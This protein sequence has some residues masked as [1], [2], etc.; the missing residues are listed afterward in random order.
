MIDGPYYARDDFNEG[1]DGMDASSIAGR[2]GTIASELDESTF[3]APGQTQD[4]DY[5]G[6]EPHSVGHSGN[7]QA[8]TSL[9]TLHRID[10]P[11]MMD[12]QASSQLRFP[13]PLDKSFQSEATVSSSSSDIVDYDKRLVGQGYEPSFPPSDALTKPRVRQSTTPHKPLNGQAANPYSKEVRDSLQSDKNEDAAPLP[14]PVG[15]PFN[16]N[17]RMILTNIVRFVVGLIVIVISTGVLP[18]WPGTSTIPKQA[19]QQC[20]G[21]SSS[22]TGNFIAR[23]TSCIEGAPTSKTSKALIVKPANNASGVLSSMTSFM[24]R[25]TSKPDASLNEVKESDI[26]RQEC[27]ALSLY[28][29]EVRSMNGV[30]IDSFDLAS[31]GEGVSRLAWNAAVERTKVASQNAKAV[32]KGLRK[33]WREWVREINEQYQS[34]VFPTFMAVSQQAVIQVKSSKESWDKAWEYALPL[35]AYFKKS[36]IEWMQNAHDLLLQLTRFI[37][38]ETTN[39]KEDLKERYRKAQGMKERYHKAQDVFNQQLKQATKGAQVAQKS[40]ARVLQ[41]ASNAVQTQKLRDDTNAVLQQAYTVMAQKRAN[42]AN[43]AVALK[44][45][46]ADEAIK[47]RIEEV[48]ALRIKHR[49]MV[50][51]IEEQNKISYKASKLINKGKVALYRKAIQSVKARHRLEDMLSEV[52]SSTPASS[53][54]SKAS[55]KAKRAK[56]GSKKSKRKVFNSKKTAAPILW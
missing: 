34:L 35:M 10:Q 49:Q 13:D 43:A 1:S 37:K 51:L 56:K 44:R 41:G 20:I 21:A 14:S 12:S 45:S 23:S 2:D 29:A 42:L 9:T 5:H 4:D 28:L 27:N 22:W 16:W 15:I 18:A 8:S 53:T 26:T 33:E 17:K 11:D 54:R 19:V 32:S 31:K 52:T 25:P 6:S 47:K 36:W 46:R 40:L 55:K 50:K 30:P 39:F 3:F 48:D 24:S 38:G 7:L